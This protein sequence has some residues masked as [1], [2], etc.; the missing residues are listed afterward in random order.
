MA[1]ETPPKPEPPPE[2]PVK[3]EPPPEPPA[4]PEPPVKPEPP[5]PPAKPEPQPWEEPLAQLTA[6]V[7]ELKAQRDAALAKAERV[8]ILRNFV[9]GLLVPPADPEFL[10]PTAHQ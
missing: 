8:P 5:E 6:E 7:A 9:K 3:P 10:K 1:K 4:K 2:P